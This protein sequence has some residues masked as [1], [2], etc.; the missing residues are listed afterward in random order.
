MKAGS[1]AVEE[2]DVRK[3]LHKYT[4]KSVETELDKAV[5]Q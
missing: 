4:G 1:I 5:I 3:Q 2:N